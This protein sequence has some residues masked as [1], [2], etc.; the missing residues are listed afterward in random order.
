MDSRE[1]YLEKAYGKE[2]QEKLLAR[3]HARRSNHWASRIKLGEELLEKYSAWCRDNGVSEPQIVLDAGC[4]IGTFAIEIAKKGYRTFGVDISPDAIRI[5]NELAEQ[6][7]V[8]EVKF[9]CGDIRQWCLPGNENP[10]S[11]DTIIAMDLIE[12]LHDHELE[13]MLR[14]FTAYLKIDGAFL[15]HTFPTR[16][17][18]IFLMCCILLNEDRLIYR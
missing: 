18:P 14:A 3:Y 8:P 15:F 6:E 1:K 4:A 11:I 12:H 17:E 7:G 16:F 2:Q 9:F 13:E 10:E 5:A